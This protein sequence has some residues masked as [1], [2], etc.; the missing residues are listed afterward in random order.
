MYYVKPLHRLDLILT[1]SNSD[2]VYGIPIK[3][4]LLTDYFTII[5]RLKLFNAKYALINYRNLKIFNINDYSN[6][7]INSL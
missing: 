3:S 5:F 7:I 4:T 2:M 6:N 1:N